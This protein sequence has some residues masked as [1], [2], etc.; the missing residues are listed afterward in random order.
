MIPAHQRLRTD[1][2]ACLHIVL[3]LEIHLELVLFQRVVH[4]VFYPLLLNLFGS[5][6][7]IV[8]GPLLDEAPFNGLLG[9]VCP[10]T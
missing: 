6:L 2:A 10:V 5:Q 4:L 1:H 3:G 8:K 9:Q 7:F